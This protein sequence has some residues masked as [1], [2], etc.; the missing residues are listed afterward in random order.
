MNLTTGALTGW[1]PNINSSLGV[2]AAKVEPV[3]HDLWAGGDFT[4]V[5]AR[6]AQYLAVFP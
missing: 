5:N 3:S 6:T 1:S 2:W 4:T